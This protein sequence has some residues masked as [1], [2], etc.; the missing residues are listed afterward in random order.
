MEVSQ[1]TDVKEYL[2]KDG[3]FPDLIAEHVF[4]SDLMTRCGVVHRL[5]DDGFES[6]QRGETRVRVW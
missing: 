4:H 5:F 3:I 1:D 6:I 2:W